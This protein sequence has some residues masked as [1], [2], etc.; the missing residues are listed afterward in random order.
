MRNQSAFPVADTV[1]TD[2]GLT[3]LEYLV[4]HNVSAAVSLMDGI[5]VRYMSV[6]NKPIGVL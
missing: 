3:K 2:C 5:S 4:A 1:S 6:E